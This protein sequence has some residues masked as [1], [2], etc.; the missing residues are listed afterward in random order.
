MSV[1]LYDAEKFYRIAVSLI[2][3]HNYGLDL[4]RFREGN[5]HLGWLFG[6]PKGW[7]DWGVIDGYIM[8]L[9]NDLYRANQITYN[10]QYPGGKQ[11]VASIDWQ[12][13]GQDNY[14]SYPHP[15]ALYKS[16]RGLHYNLI[17]NAGRSTEFNKS[18]EL[19][20]SLIDALGYEIISHSPAWDKYDTW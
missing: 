5:A 11:S 16:L 18:L 6:Y 2:R 1:M 19:L 17:D 14:E 4:P 3:W 8:N 12:L 10:R 15:V 20:N 7:K 13:V 9:V